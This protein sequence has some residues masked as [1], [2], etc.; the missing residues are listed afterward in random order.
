MCVEREPEVCITVRKLAM[1]STM[2][3]F[4]DIVPGYVYYTTLNIEHL[5][6]PCLIWRYSFVN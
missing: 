4:K 2:A 3:V 5:T 1:V 6:C